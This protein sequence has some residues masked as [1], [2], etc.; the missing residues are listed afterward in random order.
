MVAEERNLASVQELTDGERALARGPREDGEGT[1]I[2]GVEAVQG[3]PTCLN[4]LPVEGCRGNT[5]GVDAV[6]G[7]KY[8]NG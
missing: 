7:G 5:L 8:E 6:R 2:R 4:G 1:G 3:F